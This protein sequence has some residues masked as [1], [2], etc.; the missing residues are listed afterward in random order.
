MTRDEI[1]DAL[2]DMR[3]KFL[4]ALED[5]SDEAL[6]EPGVFADWSIKDILY[7]LSMWEAELVKLLWQAAQGQRPTTAH[8]SGSPTPVD[9]INADWL[10]KGR[11]RPLELVWQD[12]EAVRKQTSRRVEAFSDE[13]LNDPQRYPWLQG[14]S[15]WEWVAGD[16]YEHEEEHLAD[17]RAWRARREK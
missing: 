3:E 7:H 10:E 17:I 6:Q 9:Q 14:R 4:E 16:S 15:L 2:E 11:E 13:D 1:L 8:F 5:L 12:F